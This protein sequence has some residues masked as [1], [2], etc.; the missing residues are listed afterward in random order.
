VSERGFVP[1][2]VQLAVLHRL[3]LSRFAV[4]GPAAEADDICR[5]ALAACRSN[6][7]APFT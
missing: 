1:R 3:F 7:D 2:L 5:M 4:A 6:S